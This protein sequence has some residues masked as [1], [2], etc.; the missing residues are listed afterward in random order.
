[1]PSKTQ[2]EIT[3]TMFMH[4]IGFIGIM[5]FTFLFISLMTGS[6]SRASGL[7]EE[8]LFQNYARRL[9]SSSDCLAYQ[10][11]ESYYDA[12]SSNI[13]YYSKIE[14]ATIDMS[15]FFDFNHQNCLRYDLVSGA[16]NN[17]PKKKEQVFPVVLYEVEV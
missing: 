5:A 8:S 15:N 1:M 11:I 3:N 17:E 13:N 6:Q 16:I 4:L 12:D 10:Y 2:M 14:P 7:K 9:L